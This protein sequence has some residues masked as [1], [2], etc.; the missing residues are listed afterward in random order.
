MPSLQF[1]QCL[2]SSSVNVLT[3][4]QSMSSLMRLVN[5]FI[6]VESTSLS[7][8][9]LTLLFLFR[10]ETD[11]G[12]MMYFPPS[13]SSGEQ[14]LSSCRSCSLPKLWPSSKQTE[15]RIIKWTSVSYWV[16][17]I[18]TQACFKRRISVASNAIQIIDHEMTYLIIYCLNCIRC[19][20][21]STSKQALLS[22]KKLIMKLIHEGCSSTS[23]R[24]ERLSEGASGIRMKA[25]DTKNKKNLTVSG[26]N[27]SLG[28]EQ[29][30]SPVDRTAE[31]CVVP[32]PTIL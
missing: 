8:S 28:G 23:N 14:T 2:Q 6:T 15:Q 12:Y 21:N 30:I 16:G 29:S 9:K 26:H 18:H 19:D 3:S 10:P 1:S 24:V 17:V 27:V 5:V 11:A 22:S 4:V 32:H 31:T 25:P 13:P 20:E 7:V